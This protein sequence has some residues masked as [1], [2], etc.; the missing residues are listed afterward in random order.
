MA[1]N[2][3]VLFA[4]PSNASRPKTS[5][6]RWRAETVLTGLGNRAFFR[7]RLTHALARSRRSGATTAV[8]FLDLDRYKEIND[9]WGHHAGDA[10][11][12]EVANRLRATLRE[13]DSI[14]RLGGDEFGI[15][16]EDIERPDDVLAV[17]ERLCSVLSEPYAVAGEELET[18]PSVGIALSPQHGESA[19]RLLKLADRAMY[20][21]KALGGTRCVLHGSD[22]QAKPA[23]FLI[24]RELRGALSKGEFVLH[25]QPQASLK[26]GECHVLEA[27]IR[28][29]RGGE[30]R[31]PADFI[32]EL[33]QTALIDDVGRW[34]IRE[35]CA[36]QQNGASTEQKT[37][38]SR[39]MSQRLSST[40]PTW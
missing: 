34:V 35:S 10:V 31:P 33:E 36:R 13:P 32:H 7:S 5:S 39:S 25:Y 12:C 22:Q 27:L 19:E 24:T 16:L 18:G 29:R 20:Q 38:A 40:A 4:M 17:G 11:I 37:C 6:T 15:L 26:S 30:L 21:A 2:S 14:A 3:S 1:N 28:W 23:R 8:I 9:G